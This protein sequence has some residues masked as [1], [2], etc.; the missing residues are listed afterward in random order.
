MS[1]NSQNFIPSINKHNRFSG[2]ENNHS[3]SPNIRPIHSSNKP[4][5]NNLFPKNQMIFNNNHHFNIKVNKITRKK[6]QII[7]GDLNFNEIS[8][9]IHLKN[10]QKNN[11]INNKLKKKGMPN[12]SPLP[13]SGAFKPKDVLSFNRIFSSNSRYLRQQEQKNLGKTNNMFRPAGNPHFMNN[14]IFGGNLNMNM[15][16]SKSFNDKNMVNKLKE[17]KVI[18]KD[19]ESSI[20]NIQNNRNKDKFNYKEY[21]EIIKISLRPNLNERNN[22]LFKHLLI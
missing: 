5:Q 20:S 9:P 10:Y 11:Y 2:K 22:E 21:D 3:L 4:I 6:E 8:K 15:N 19:N 14:Y 12:K 7:E 13:I 16:M 18:D 1:F 17:V